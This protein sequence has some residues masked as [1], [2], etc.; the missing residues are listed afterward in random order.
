MRKY[1]HIVQYAFLLL[2]GYALALKLSNIEQ[3]KNEM[4]M[5][6]FPAWVADI[7]WWL[8]PAIQVVLVL[9]LLFRPTIDRGVQASTLLITAIN[10]YLLLGVTK[11]FGST[12]CACGGIWPG[13]NHWEHIAWNSIFMTLGIL[14]GVLAHRSRPVRDVSADVDRKEGAVF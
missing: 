13:N 14:Y 12:P 9:L 11:V 8:I 4:A 5:Q 10:I 2:W 3:T 1:K 7:L 6:L